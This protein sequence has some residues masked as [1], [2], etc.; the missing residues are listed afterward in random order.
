MSLPKTPPQ[1][2]PPC[3]HLKND[4]SPLG[5][6][7]NPSAPAS[8]WASKGR[9]EPI[10]CPFAQRDNDEQLEIGTETTASMESLGKE[11]NVKGGRE[12]NP[13]KK[14]WVGERCQITCRVILFTSA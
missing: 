11:K 9:S 13:L 6:Q 2:Y 8:K 4:S 7:L 10:K 12:R 3:P 14:L 1:C 5:A